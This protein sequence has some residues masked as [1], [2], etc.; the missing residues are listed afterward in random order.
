MAHT[1]ASNF[2]HCIFGTKQRRALIPPDRSP[3]LYN[4]LGAV[5]KSEG[6]S[7]ITAGGT[8]DHVHLLFLL[9]ATHSLAHSVQKLKGSSSHWMGAGFAWQEGY[10]AFSVSASQVPAVKSYIASQEQHHHK[11]SFEEEFTTLLRSCGIDYDPQYV[12]G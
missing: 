8:A 12:F 11:R 5:A 6:F 1:Y 2:I 10:G 4:Y 3:H 7:L 9:P